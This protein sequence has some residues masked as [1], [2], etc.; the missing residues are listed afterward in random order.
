MRLLHV[1][2]RPEL[3]ETFLYPGGGWHPIW[4]ENAYWRKY[5]EM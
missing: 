5:Q 1:S 2:Y 3:Q 4:E